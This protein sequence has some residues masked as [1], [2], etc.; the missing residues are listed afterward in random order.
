[1]IAFETQEKGT[2][3]EKTKTGQ[4]REGGGTGKEN[5]R[6]KQKRRKIFICSPYRPIGKTKKERQEDLE[7]NLRLA[8]YAADYVIQNGNIPYAP[9]LYFP[10]LLDDNDPEERRMGTLFGLIWL[11]GCDEVWVVGRIISDGMGREIGMAHELGIPVRH[12]L[13]GAT[14]EEQI[15]EALFEDDWM[16]D[17]EEEGD[18]S[19]E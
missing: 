18:E 17:D 8:R 16:S 2:G 14:R 19:D 3:P 1:M 7:W 11:A 10:Q 13:C 15:L 9:H 12:F 4:D 5:K 6:N